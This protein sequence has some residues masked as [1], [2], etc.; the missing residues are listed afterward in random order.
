MVILAKANEKGKKDIIPPASD[1][2]VWVHDLK[3]SYRQSW[4]TFMAHKYFKT[5]TN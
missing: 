1:M 2:T 3:T 5:H 4:D